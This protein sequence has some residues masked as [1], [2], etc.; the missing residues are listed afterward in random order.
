MMPTIELVEFAETGEVMV[1]EYKSYEF[2]AKVTKDCPKE[3]S[4]QVVQAGKETY[5][6]TARQCANAEQS[7]YSERE[8]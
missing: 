6:M 3:L 1:S 2:D 7:D 8:L 5:I 4:Q